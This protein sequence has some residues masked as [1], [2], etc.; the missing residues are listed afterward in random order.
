MPKRAP[1]AVR[2]VR[3]DRVLERNVVRRGRWRL[4]LWTGVIALVVMPWWSFQDHTHWARVRWIPFVSLPFSVGDILRN[5]LLY[6]PWGYLYARQP[7]EARRSVWRAAGYALAL[8]VTTE[9][10]QLW[11]HGRFPSTTDVICN[12]AGA[13][14]GAVWARRRTSTRKPP[15]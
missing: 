14:G 4:A 15:E 12:V 10:T 1:A 3:A 13:W 5:F 9:A 8:S 2:P 11:S 7:R 6:L